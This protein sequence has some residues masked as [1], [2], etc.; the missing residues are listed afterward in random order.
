MSSLRLTDSH[1]HLGAKDLRDDVAAIL[2][3]AKAEGIVQW[4][5]VSLEPGDAADVLALA[6]AH[7]GVFGAV[8]LHPHEATSWSEAEAELLR[9]QAGHAKLVAI[10]EMGLDYHYDRSPREQQQQVFREQVRLAREM[11]L[12]IVVHTREA[13]EDT[14]R[15]LEEE[16]AGDVG[17]VIHCFTSSSRLAERCL[18]LGFYISLS[19][20]VTY[21]SATD[22]QAVAKVL[23]IDKLMVETDC[24]YLAPAPLRR[25]WP[26]EPAFVRHTAEF[27]ADLR[28]E[29]LEELA[30]ATTANF[31]SLFLS[32]R[33]SGRPT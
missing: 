2:E 5:T 28:G 12:P 16:Q 33:A 22:L 4:L 20:I 9:A 8:G 7:D 13:E 29:S 14:A 25:H 17:G 31:E 24:P 27:L 26:N 1:A 18:A 15:I 30:V 10:G 3:R 21:P 11:K 23:P 19:G 6:A 32:G